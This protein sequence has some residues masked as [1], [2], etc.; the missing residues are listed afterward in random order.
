MAKEM[1]AG[2]KRIKVERKEQRI[3]ESMKLKKKR[4]IWNFRMKSMSKTYNEN[5]WKFATFILF[6]IVF[7]LAINNYYEG[8][9]QEINEDKRI[10]SMVTATPSWVND[11]GGIIG[12]G[13]LQPMNQTTTNKTMVDY[14]I[15]NKIKFVYNPKC[16]ACEYQIKLLGTEWEEYKQSGLT[17]DCSSLGEIK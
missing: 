6:G 2:L 3:K 17:L 15:E 10:C 1:F 14:L 11:D 13:V 7:I 5:P 12:V 8:Y 4:R 9:K 16:S